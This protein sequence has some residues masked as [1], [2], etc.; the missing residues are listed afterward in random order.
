MFSLLTYSTATTYPFATLSLL[1][2]LFYTLQI[3]FHNSTSPLRKIPGP[4]LARYTRFWLWKS[5]VARDWHKTSVALHRHIDDPEAAKV[6]F[7]SRNQLEKAQWYHVFTAPGEPEGIFT[8]RSNAQHLSRRRQVNEFYTTSAIHKI[9]YRIDSVTELFLSKLAHMAKSEQNTPFDMCQ[10]IRFY[11]YDALANITFGQMFGTLEK[12]SDVNGLIETIAA[13]IRYGQVVGVFVEW[14]PIIIRLLQALTP[15]GNKGLLHLK[16]IGENAMKRMDSDPTSSESTN[17]NELVLKQE[18]SQERPHSFVSVMQERHLKDPSNFSRDDATSHMLPNIIAGADTTS[19]TVN[20]AVY[21]LW[22]NARVLAKLRDELDKWAAAKAPR[23]TVISMAEAQELPYLQA[24]L[25]ETMRMFPGLGNNLVRV[26]P[27]GG[28]T[29][30]KQFFPA[31]TVV[32]MNAF[33]AHANRD[34]FGQDADEFRPE[35]WLGDEDTVAQM[36]QYFL[37][38]GR[39]PRNCVGRNI[40]LVMLNTVIPELVLRFEFIPVDPEKEWTIHNDAFMYQE[41]FQVEIRERMVGD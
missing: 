9:A 22:R 36:D 1:P 27:D 5:V 12:T 16:S 4:W 34:V 10:M 11:A 38:F 15:G 32:G 20:A 41:D 8:I 2:L 21:Y 33:V 7:R 18:K 24:V 30:V 14:H 19:A 17:N 6:I 3:V 37:S 31:G 23:R 26:V 40:A 13:F 35:P 28:L 25:K 39:G 29:I